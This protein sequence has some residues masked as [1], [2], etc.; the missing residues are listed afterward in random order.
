MKPLQSFLAM[1]TLCCLSLAQQPPDPILQSGQ[2]PKYPPLALGA[3]IEGE[4]K[5][6]FI[7]DNKGEVTSVEVLSGHPMLR[8]ATAAIV[9]SW[10]F[11][12][13]KN[14]FRT[15]WKYDTTF[16]YHLSGREL[17]SNETAKLTV[18]VDSFHQ[19]EV[20]SDAYKPIMQYSR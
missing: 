4:V 18:V 3:R 12:L 19:I 13:P 15:E 10:K 16:R 7:L 8:E 17:K 11:D 6:S 5:V 9:K 20:M 1:L 2:M 14:L